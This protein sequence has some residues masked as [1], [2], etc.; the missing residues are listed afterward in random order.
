MTRRKRGATPRSPGSADLERILSNIGDI[1]AADQLRFQAD[2]LRNVQYMV[3]ATDLDGRITYW[4]EGATAIFGYGPEVMLGK[5]AAILYPDQDPR[6]LAADMERVLQGTDY[7]GEWLGRR[8]DGSAVWLDVRT[9]VLRGRDGRP[10]GFLGVAKDVTERR[11]AEAALQQS[12]D[13]YRD[14][15]EHSQDLICI[16]DLDGLL[17]SIN[18]WAA[19]MLGYE[20][21][22]MLGMSVRDVLAPE[23]RHEFD[24]YIAA[25]RTEGA[26]QGLMLLQT[27]TGEKRIWEYR[28]TLRTEGVAAP[29][30]RGMA[31]DVTARRRAEQA[32]R[33]SEERYRTLFETATDAVYVTTRSGQLLDVNEAAAELWGGPRDE[34][35]RLNANELYVDLRD[36]DRFVEAVERQGVAR[37]IEVRARRRDGTVRDCLGSGSARRT[38]DGTVIGY[39]GIAHDITG[40]KKAEDV[41]RTSRDRLRALAVELH[42]VREEERTAVA[43][44][45]HDEFGQALTGLKMDLT[46]LVD[47]CASGPTE[48]PERLGAMLELVDRSVDAVRRLAA[49]LRPAV[50]DDLGI[51][52][53]IE[54]LAEDL[55]KHSG[56]ECHCEVPAQE[57]P[58]GTD[59]ATAVFRIAQEALTNVARHSGAR[60]VEIAFTATDEGVGLEVRDDGK[61]ITEDQ[62]AS[63]RSIGLIGMRERAGSLGGRVYVRPGVER[64]T[65]VTLELPFKGP[66]LPAAGP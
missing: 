24:Q 38:A 33:E 29:V 42:K 5:T 43:R 10:S 46:W 53:A 39:Q 23:V 36:R 51:A 9:T 37:N 49:H 55:S 63:V 58:L 31:R 47:R 59:R 8:K 27:R 65:I 4:N 56:I 60:Q 6:A 54:W 41:V 52:A 21:A 25:I 45:I 64:G 3:I 48:V 1:T 34:L 57:P 44:E 20:P 7:L 22:E 66:G 13:Q 14:L 15:V 28:N 18:P 16:H 50:L 2:I 19:R 62:V 30:V 26:A 17:L 61:G 35:L 11:R 40:R 12:E 32:L